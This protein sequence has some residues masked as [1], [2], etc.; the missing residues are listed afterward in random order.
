MIRSVLLILLTSQVES[1]AP[2]RGSAFLGRRIS[3]PSP[4]HH[5]KATA[6][7]TTTLMMGLDMVTYM[8]TEWISAALCTNQTPRSADVVLQLGSE[9]G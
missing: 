9:D 3:R 8:R 4:D 7:T 6:S 2:A 5:A 1:F